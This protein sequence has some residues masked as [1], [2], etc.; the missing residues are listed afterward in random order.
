MIISMT[1]G[2][3]QLKISDKVITLNGE[4]YLPGHGSPDFVVYS[5]MIKKWD[6]PFDEEQLTE[7]D[8]KIIFEMLRKDAEQ[9]KMKIEIE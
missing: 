3:I 2:T 8:K 1:R 4:A 6:A 7:D 9:V 5:N